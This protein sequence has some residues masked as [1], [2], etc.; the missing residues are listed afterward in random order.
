MHLT[1]QCRL[2][3]FLE[4]YSYFEQLCLLI[5]FKMKSD[6]NVMKVNLFSFSMPFYRVN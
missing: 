3:Q 2:C 5:G 6:R 1:A 4:C